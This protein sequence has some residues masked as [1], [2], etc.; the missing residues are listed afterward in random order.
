VNSVDV[1]DSSRDVI[2]TKYQEG[3]PIVKVKG[4][5]KCIAAF[6]EHV[7]ARRFIRD[8]IV[9]GCKIPF[10]YTPP[11]ASFGKNRSAFQHSEFV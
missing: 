8:T 4:S 10:I 3:V 1:P 2:S 6:W 7:G 5:L 11:T 9:Y